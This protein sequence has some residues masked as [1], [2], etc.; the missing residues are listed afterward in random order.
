MIRRQGH[1]CSIVSCLWLFQ[2]YTFAFAKD[3]A[4]CTITSANDHT[5]ITALTGT[6]ICHAKQSHGV[7]LLRH[8]DRMFPL[9]VSTTLHTDTPSKACILVLAACLHSDAYEWC[10]MHLLA[11]A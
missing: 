8:H 9:Q 5:T 6:A 3:E 11:T 2:S 1:V 7:M 10:M 4:I